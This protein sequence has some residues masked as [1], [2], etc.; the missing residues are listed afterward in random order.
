M[1]AARVKLTKRVSLPS[2]EASL[3][4]SLCPEMCMICKKKDLKLKH[5]RQLQS[6]IVTKTIE[7]K[8]L[9]EATFTRNDKEMIIVVSEAYLTANQFQKHKKCY[10]DCTRIVIKNSPAAESKSEETCSGNRNYDS[11]L[12]LID[13]DVFASQQCLSMET[14]IMEYNG[15]IE[16][17]QSRIKLT[18]RLLN[19]YSDNLSFF[20]LTSTPNK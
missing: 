9:K 13:N 18:E 15:S 16:T 12:S 19:S 14:I 6:K 10:L 1:K 5:S 17:N 2:A 20:R 7:K 4:R 8:T 3:P 11:V